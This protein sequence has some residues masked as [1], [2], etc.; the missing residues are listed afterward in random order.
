MEQWKQ[1]GTGDKE[2]CH[3]C[4]ITY[5]IFSTFPSMPSAMAMNVETGGFFPMDRLRSYSNGHDMADALGYAWA[6]NCRERTPKRHDEQFTVRDA[7]GRPLSGVRYRIRTG[8][9]VVAS[10]ITDSDGRTVRIRSNRS[11]RL[12]LEMA[13]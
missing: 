5:S 11:Q 12:I 6:C 1:K 3:L 7:S 9:D 4:R 2:E 10:G 13:H 8:V